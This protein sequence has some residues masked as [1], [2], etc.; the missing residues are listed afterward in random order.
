MF[1]RPSTDE[2]I[3]A[4]VRK[5]RELLSLNASAREFNVVYGDYPEKDT[6]IAMLS[7]S[8]YEVLRDLSANITVPE[9]DVT[10]RRVPPTPEA[11]LG[12]EGPIPPLIRIASSAD[13]PGDA[14]VAVPY[15]GHWFSIDD[16]D[17]PS[18][19]LFSFIMFLFTFVEKAGQDVAPI[20][21]IPTT[22]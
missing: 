10:E 16:R 21:T 17:L 2:A 9:A 12:P 8:I 5:I 6:E 7:R 4:L 1:V 13:R 18:K 19:N 3:T 14:F 20:L 22:R 15:R 11:D